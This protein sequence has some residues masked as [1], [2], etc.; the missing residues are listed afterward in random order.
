V[1]KFLALAAVVLVALLAFHFISTSARAAAAQPAAG[2]AATPAASQNDVQAAVAQSPEAQKAMADLEKSAAEID[3]FVSDQPKDGSAAPD[4]TVQLSSRFGSRPPRKCP[5]IAS[6]PTAAQAATLVQCTMDN[7]TP[8]QANLHQDITVRLSSPRG[9][10][11]SD[12]WPEI[13]SRARVVDFAANATVYLC[14]P[15]LE[16]VMHNTGANCDRYQFES[17]PGICWKTIQGSYRCQIN[18]G[19][20]MKPE[21]NQPPPTTY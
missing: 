2:Q 18:A 11:N 12:R 4:P 8:Q 3:K 20:P 6:P 17:A 21:R 5:S 9:P 13:D 1:K 16:A 14:G 7:E 19:L 15:V 10:T